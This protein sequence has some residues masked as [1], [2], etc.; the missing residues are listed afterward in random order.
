VA[1]WVRR[2]RSG[3]YK[4][5][6][7]EQSREVVLSLGAQ[8]DE[9]LD[10]D[11]PLVRRLFPPPYEDDQERNEGFAA[12]AVPELIE[13]RRESLMVIRSTINA[14]QLTEDELMAWMR[15]INDIRLVLGTLLGIEDDREDIYEAIAADPEHRSTWAAYEYL[16]GIL[17]QIVQA[18]GR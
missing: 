17:E 14:T 3:D 9:L 13:K 10:T 2:S 4:I 12:L 18:L 6:L 1:R 8:V 11:S 16:G 15:S 5:D 7:P